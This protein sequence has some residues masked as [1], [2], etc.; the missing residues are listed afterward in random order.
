MPDD[1]SLLTKLVSELGKGNVLT[2]PEHIYVYSHFGEFGI[3]PFHQPL[4]IV[5]LG[6]NLDES[7]LTELLEGSGVRIVR[8]DQ[9]EM[10]EEYQGPYIL[11]DAQKPVTIDS[12]INRLYELD[13][14]R[15]E[16]KQTLKDVSSFSHWLVS[17]LQGR[18]GYRLW[19]NEED[20]GFCVVQSYFDNVQTYSSKGRLL[21]AKGYLNGDLEESELLSDSIY[22]CTACG[23]C[24]DQ[25]SLDSL[26][27][28]NLIIKTRNK[29][30]QGNNAPKNFNTA[31]ENIKAQGNPAGLP[32][33]D[34]VL[35]IEEQ[36]EKHPYKD[37]PVLFWPGCTTSYRLP[38]LVEDTC[39]ILEEADYDFGLLG[40]NEGCCGLIL[41]LSGHWDEARR[42]GEK[43]LE[44]L[45]G[46]KRLVTNCSGCYYCFSRVYPI[47]GL[48]VPFD[49]LHTSQIIKESIQDGRLQL[50]E[51][52]GS[53]T[54]HD[55]CDLGRHSH[56]FEP[57]RYVLE[58]IPGLNLVEPILNR[59]HAVCCGAGG[60]LWMYREELTNHVS[61]MKLAETLPDNIDGIIT[62]CPTCLLSLRNTAREKKPSLR[63]L[64][65]VEVVKSCIQTPN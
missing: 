18:D 50:K 65:L 25:V 32:Q 31:L 1:M 11:L 27:V 13:E 30:T 10:V 8:S 7:G 33:E 51:Y 62:G 40:E 42:N 35:W 20:I 12:L 52:R 38:E 4:A 53:F 47:L 39:E 41:Y 59:E 37:N 34:R 5:R 17:S 16:Q 15:G 21:L 19:E 56:V 54:W 9:H 6:D 49:V 23:Q 48:N 60:G 28:N 58:S 46:V 3:K 44:S 29:L 22:S 14:K 63:V 43:I 36:V 24:Y 61:Q 26:E 57:P 64:D 45:D 55:P 2:D